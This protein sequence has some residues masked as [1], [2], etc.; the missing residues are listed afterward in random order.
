MK[1][2]QILKKIH[3]LEYQSSSNKWF[4]IY[5][6]KVKS[7]IEAH[8]NC[9]LRFE[10]EDTY[11]D[12]TLSKINLLK[13]RPMCLSHGDFHTANMI[14]SPDNKLFIIDFGRVEIVDPFSAFKSMI[15]S[16]DV[17]SYFTTGQIDAYFNNRIPNEFWELL[18]YYSI[19]V[20]ISSL[21]WAV[22]Y[23]QKEVDLAYKRIE[24]IGKWYSNINSNIPTWYIKNL[25]K[26]NF[27]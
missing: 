12:Y 4:D 2:G 17:S 6:Q 5:S 14:I 18:K 27:D 23:G 3:T 16:N 8:K 9:G 24:S 15:F 10:K 1:A 13:N 11:I 21:A 25:N 22:F 19:S 20:T 7:Y 26:N